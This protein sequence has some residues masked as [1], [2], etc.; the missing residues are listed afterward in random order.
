[1]RLILFMC[2][3]AGVWAQPTVEI[4]HVIGRASDRLTEAEHRWRTAQRAAWR[5]I[6]TPEEK[7]VVSAVTELYR[8]LFQPELGSAPKIVTLTDKGQDILVARW[9]AK[10]SQGWFSELIVWDTPNQTSF[11][12]RLP[13][14]S[15]SSDAQIRSSFERLLLPPTADGRSPAAK[16]V[17]VNVAKDAYTGR[18]IG[19]GGFPNKPIPR[20]IDI[21]LLNWLDL[22]QSADSSYLAA[23]FRQ[24]DTPGFRWEMRSIAERFPPLESR[25]GNWSTR[26][27]LD[28]LGHGGF[29][30]DRRDRILAKE[31]M[32][33]PVTDEELL[34]V[35]MR[36]KPDLSGE[37]LFVIVQEHQVA[38]FEGAIHKY[39]QADRGCG[40][41][42]EPF[43][44]LSNS[45]EVNFTDVAL[46]VLRRGP[47]DYAPFA[48]V[49]DHGTTAAEYKA[50]LE[51]RPRYPFGYE[52]L[53]QRMRPRLGLA[54]DG[55][56]K[57]P[58]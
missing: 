8:G 33:R 48:Y 55:S 41:C 2:L 4:H 13:R 18:W 47:V 22:W 49:S 7:D 14:G 5:G 57:P 32:R 25:V 20:Q 3:V 58:R 56:P 17:T 1:M 40:Q 37:L 29:D 19:A 28:E 45:G 12:F 43:T 52:Y 11:I 53:L 34:E 50:L 6:E 35:L 16:G 46:E 26:R 42:N 51:V 23:G 24:F 54:E 38:H 39:L 9:T 27:I 44:L 21:G 31:L 30:A 10:D 36:R 15:W